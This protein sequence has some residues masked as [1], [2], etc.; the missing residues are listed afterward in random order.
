DALVVDRRGDQ[1]SRPDGRQVEPRLR[2]REAADEVLRERLRPEALQRPAHVLDQAGP[3]DVLRRDELDEAA[4]D[5]GI[6]GEGF[7]QQVLDVEDLDV[8]LAQPGDELVVLLLGALD[9]QHV[10]EQ[11]LVMVPGRQALQAQVRPMDDDLAELADLRRDVEPGRRPLGGAGAGPVGG[12]CRRCHA[13]TPGTT[14]VPAV[15]AS[16]PSISASEPITARLPVTETNSRAAWTLGPMDP[17][18]N[19]RPARSSGVTRSRWRWFGA[20]QSA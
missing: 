2:D 11:E 18:A 16:R 10:I 20:P 1:R 7:R 17:A 6:G 8:A 9:P 4:P 3:H 12:G 15:P 19:S 14:L 13:M 5:P